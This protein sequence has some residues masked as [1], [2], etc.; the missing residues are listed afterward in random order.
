MC[1]NCNVTLTVIVVEW[2][3]RIEIVLQTVVVT[4]CKF[5]IVRFPCNGPVR[6]VSP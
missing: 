3:C 2:K 4:D 6:E 5:N 1:L